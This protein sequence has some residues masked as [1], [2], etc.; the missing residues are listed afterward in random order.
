MVF[1]TF[2]KGVAIVFHPNK[3]SHARLG[4]K[5][6]LLT[7]YRFAAVP[8]IITAAVALI[9]YLVF[10]PSL[11]NSL[12]MLPKSDLV[13]GSV[14]LTI[15]AYKDMLLS[16]VVMPMLPIPIALLVI[17]GLIHLLGKVFRMF[18]EGF[19][20]TFT[21]VLYASFSSL[22]FWFAIVFG[23]IG[24]VVY[25]LAL[26]YG[27]YVLVVGLA[28]QQDTTM[29]NAFVVGLAAFVILFI[30]ASTIAVGNV[31]ALGG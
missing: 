24:G 16:L 13:G 29:T 26:V 3:E 1:D 11:Q 6:A 17:A 10:G 25:F 28:K 14:A 4:L 5:E 15:L 23:A 19:D 31:P 20:R 7:Y 9:S 30:V 2:R 22:T 27:I 18:K 8:I 12:S 21:A